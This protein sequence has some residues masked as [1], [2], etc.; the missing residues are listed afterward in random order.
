[1]KKY[2]TL[3]ATIL[4]AG[5]VFVEATS[6][7]YSDWLLPFDVEMIPGT[8]PD[9][10]TAAQDGCPAPAK[11]GLSIYMASNRPGGQ[12][13][14][15]IWVARRERV[16]HPWGE[17]QNLGAPINTSADEFCPTPLPDGHHL[18]FVSRKSGGCGGSDMYV[19]RRDRKGQ[20]Q[21]PMHLGC[22]VNSA[23]DEASP[24][25]LEYEGGRRD[26]FF[27]STRAGGFVEE[28][29]GAVSGDSDIYVS[30]VGRGGW[31]AAPILVAHVNT[32]YEDARPNLRRDGL[33]LVF[34]SNRPGGSGGFDI[35]TAT[36]RKPRGNWSQPTNVFTV[37]TDLNETRPFL[38]WDAKTLYLGR[39]PAGAP[40]DIFVTTRLRY[41]HR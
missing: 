33:E 5:A 41:P 35:W 40:G 34:D 13:G 3:V 10:N 27:S 15:D 38:T 18:L 9:F 2:G 31:I 4:V 8:H 23:A 36:S 19:A 16:D 14:L 24:P 21:T 39:A 11:D 29:P 6:T 37:N 25:L 26:L 20:W 30:R 32:Q 17:P 22:S 28:A 1:M 7:S 12:G